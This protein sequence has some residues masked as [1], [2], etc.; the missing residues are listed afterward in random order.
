MG[1]AFSMNDRTSRLFFL[2][3][4]ALR[5]RKNEGG[6]KMGVFV[7]FSTLHRNKS[8]RQTLK[9]RAQRHI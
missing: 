3:V 4:A 2:Y 6:R 1:K 8:G 5:T 9:E 7:S